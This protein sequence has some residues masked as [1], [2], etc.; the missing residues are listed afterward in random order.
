MPDH[1]G[2][3]SFSLS[4]TTQAVNPSS[5]GPSSR[6]SCFR[7]SSCA[8]LLDVTSITKVDNVASDDVR[9]GAARP[10]LRSRWSAYS[11]ESSSATCSDSGSIGSF[12]TEYDADDG[13]TAVHNLRVASEWSA[14]TAV[15]EPL[16]PN[17]PLAGVFDNIIHS[18]T[19]SLEHFPGL[20]SDDSDND[21]VDVAI[22]VQPD[23]KSVV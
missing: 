21:E 17:S 11:S 1:G 22:A 5:Q 23:R 16:C 8:T 2:N 19:E 15:N 10:V 9:C 14:H 20:N 12:S 6:T 18:S 7:G 4:P 3:S 13:S